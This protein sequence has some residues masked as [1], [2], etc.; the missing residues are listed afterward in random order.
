MAVAEGEGG[1]GPKLDGGDGWWDVGW[2]R[3]V[4]ESPG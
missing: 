3:G 2:D 1:Y 4:L